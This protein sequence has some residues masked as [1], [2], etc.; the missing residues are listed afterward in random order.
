[1]GNP[2]KFKLG[3]R[4]EYTMTRVTDLRDDLQPESP[5]WL[6]KSPLAGGGACCGGR[7]TGRKTYYY[8]YY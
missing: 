5:V 2:T 7:R 8:Y 4:M 1:M 3:I 6:F